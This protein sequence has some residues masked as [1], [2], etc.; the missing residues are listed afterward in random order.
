M[1]KNF[2]EAWMKALGSPS[3]T[4]IMP[5]PASHTSMRLTAQPSLPDLIKAVLRGS[6]SAAEEAA[7]FLIFSIMISEKGI[8]DKKHHL[9]KKKVHSTNLRADPTSQRL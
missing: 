2:T 5:T 9:I 6:K 1:Q 4:Q 3:S 8:R 7:M